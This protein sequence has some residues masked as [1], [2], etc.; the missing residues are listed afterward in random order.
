MGYFSRGEFLD[1]E[2][3]CFNLMQPHGLLLIFRSRASA[4]SLFQSYAV[5]RTATLE[6]CVKLCAYDV[7][8]LCSHM[9]YFSRGE[10]LDLEYYCFN[11]MQPHGLLL[12]FRSRASAASLFQSYAVARTA[13]A[14]IHNDYILCMMRHCVSCRFLGAVIMV[15]C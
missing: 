8:I 3:Y 9:G 7:S 6:N 2:Y 13:S 12:I 11:L 4:A 10:F 15:L 1:L 5:A 14:K